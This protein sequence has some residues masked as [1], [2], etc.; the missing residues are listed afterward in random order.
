MKYF[1]LILTLF[2]IGCSEKIQYIK[3]QFPE[4]LEKPQAQDYILKIMEI[5]GHKYFVFEEEDALKASE[6]WIKYKNWAEGNY[7]LLKSLKH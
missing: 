4:P 1:L 3:P 5:D 7:N 2:F 6:N